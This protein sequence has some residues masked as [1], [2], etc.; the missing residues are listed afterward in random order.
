MKN[1]LQYTISQTECDILSRENE[2]L[3]K[4]DKKLLLETKSR[5]SQEITQLLMFGK[6]QELLRYMQLAPFQTKEMQGLLFQLQNIERVLDGAQVYGIL[7]NKL[8]SQYAVQLDMEF[9]NKNPL[10]LVEFANTWHQIGV[11]LSSSHSES[12]LK[13]FKD[14]WKASGKHVSSGK[15]RL[16]YYSNRMEYFMG[17]LKKHKSLDFDDVD[18]WIHDHL[19]L[20]GYKDRNEVITMIVEQVN[21]D[22][23]EVLMEW[24]KANPLYVFVICFVLF[25]ASFAG[26]AYYDKEKVDPI[27]D[28]TSADTVRTKLKNVTPLDLNKPVK[29]SSDRYKESD[30]DKNEILRMD[31]E[32]HLEKTAQT[33]QFSKNNFSEGSVHHASGGRIVLPK[34]SIGILPYVFFS[35][36]LPSFSN[37]SN[38]SEQAMRE[39]KEKTEIYTELYMKFKNRQYYSVFATNNGSGINK[40]RV[41]QFLMTLSDGKKAHVVHFG[42]FRNEDGSF[43]KEE[44]YADIE[45]IEFFCSDWEAPISATSSRVYS[46]LI[47]SKK[48]G[49]IPLDIHIFDK[50]VK[51]SFVSNLGVAIPSLKNI[52]MGNSEGLYR[53]I[54]GSMLNNQKKLGMMERDVFVAVMDSLF[55]V[56]MRP[57]KNGSLQKFQNELRLEMNS[58]KK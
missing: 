22:Q 4:K 13:A 2:A 55:S 5:F 51:V 3:D 1:S 37:D 36:D 24:A 30:A 25:G 12:E 21:E 10:A 32:A 48:H 42:P 14:C 47:R 53:R 44:L 16:K 58:K 18:P 19:Q 23:W 31:V 15:N 56:V 57:W 29:N 33:Y 52:H 11:W 38:I 26:M 41:L 20:V 17:L 43:I 27:L 50:E 28:N 54:D 39:L 6:V 46:A 7:Q 40:N 34:P 49:L 8:D 45:G 9:L 35:E